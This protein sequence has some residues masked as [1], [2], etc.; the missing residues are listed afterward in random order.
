[1]KKSIVLPM[2]FILLS[3]IASHAQWD[4]DDSPSDS[5]SRLKYSDLV[6]TIDP[7]FRG[8]PYDFGTLTKLRI[9]CE[10]QIANDTNLCVAFNEQSLVEKQSYFGYYP[11][12][13][14]PYKVFAI[15][16][17][18]NDC[19]TSRLGK[20]N[21]NILKSISC[22]KGVRAEVVKSPFAK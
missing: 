10:N 18:S 12:H 16:T 4:G 14:G 19:R 7:D 22:V 21:P 13:L 2:L 5:S 15:S 17:L 6:I 3:S 11:Q 20:Y 9:N 8:Q 1:M